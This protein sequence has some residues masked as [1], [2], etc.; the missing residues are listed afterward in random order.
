VIPVAQMQWARWTDGPRRG[1]AVRG[2]DMVL[3][4]GDVVYVEAVANQ[5][6]VFA[7]RQPPEIQGGLVVMDPFTGRV[8]A[9]VGGFSFADSVFNRATQAFRQPGS[10]FK[11]LLYAAALDNGYSPASVVLDAP[12][13]MDQGASRRTW[14]CRWSRNTRAASASTMTCPRCSP[15]RS[16][17]ARQPCCAWSRATR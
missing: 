15:C 8:L 14:A 3:S 16:A 1:Q 17:R 9:M 10:S 13:E 2:T 5:Q 6:G 4:P 7:L 12:F 11:P